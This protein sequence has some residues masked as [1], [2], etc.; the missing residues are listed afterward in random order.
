MKLTEET[1]G[2]LR[3]LL[4]KKLIVWVVATVALFMKLI[5]GSSWVIITTAYLGVEVGQKWILGK[6]PSNMPLS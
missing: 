3:S 5:D 4:S 2:R 1:K 6:G